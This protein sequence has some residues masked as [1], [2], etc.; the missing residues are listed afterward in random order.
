MASTTLRKE[1][2]YDVPRRRPFARVIDRQKL[3]LANV[4]MSICTR[5]RPSISAVVSLYLRINAITSAFDGVPSL[6]SKAAELQGVGVALWTELTANC[7]CS[8]V[9]GSDRAFSGPCLVFYRKTGNA[10][11]IANFHCL[12]NFSC[13][14][15]P[16]D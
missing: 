3:T 2:T 9:F 11:L 8:L 4:V 16:R 5:K 13:L 6:T 14:Q 15:C 10:T 1:G 12:R 7:P